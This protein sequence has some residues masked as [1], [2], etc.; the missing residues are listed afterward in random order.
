LGPIVHEIA[1]RD[2]IW[3]LFRGGICFNLAGIAVPSGNDRVSY[4]V[5]SDAIWSN[6]RDMF[7]RVRNGA[8]ILNVA[9]DEAWA[10]EA[11]RPPA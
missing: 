9:V 2:V 10:P 4:G 7:V 3:W 11:G 6:A 5:S 1:R 8:R